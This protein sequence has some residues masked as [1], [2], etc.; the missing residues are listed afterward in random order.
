M[1]HTFK[2]HFSNL[3]RT[4]MSAAVVIFCI[5]FGAG[6]AFAQSREG[7]EANLQLPDLSTVTFFNGSIDGHRLLSVGLVVCML[8]LLFGLAIYMNLKKLPV[9]RA[10][11]E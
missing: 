3:G 9:H 2:H 7:G 10:M 8:G 5:A 4:L 11:R 1:R 6:S